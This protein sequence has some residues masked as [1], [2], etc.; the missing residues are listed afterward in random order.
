MTTT[1]TTNARHILLRL[2]EGRLPDALL[3]SLRD[4]VV[5]S[6]WLRGSGVLADVTLRTLGTQR[7]LGGQLQA[8]VLDATLGFANG[9]VTCTLRGVFARETDAGLETFAGEIVDAR[10]VSLEANITA[11]DDVVAARPE[12][13]APAAAPPA[14]APAPPPA[15]AW[16]DA[17]VAAAAPPVQ[18]PPPPAPAPAPAPAAPKPS[19]TFS[20]SGGP[21][22]MKP[23]KP[24]R[25]EEEEQPTPEPGDLVEHFAFGRCEVVKSDGDRLHVRLG[26]DGRIKEIALEMLKVTSLAPVEGATGKH[27]RLDR[28]I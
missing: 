8:V 22:P 13:P 3:A 19:P 15:Q 2:G 20:A 17:A 23:F 28:R 14:P 1:T 5:L 7:R 26:K 24:V 18:P 16:A 10:I 21:L 25:A 12:A 4:E 27:Y 9:D 6:G 11:L